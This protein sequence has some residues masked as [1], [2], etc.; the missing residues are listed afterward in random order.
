MVVHG[1]TMFAPLQHNEGTWRS[2]NGPY[3]MVV[4]VIIIRKKLSNKLNSGLNYSIKKKIE[5]VIYIY[6]IPFA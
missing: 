2:Y 3:P 5:I 6:N 4:T 1:L